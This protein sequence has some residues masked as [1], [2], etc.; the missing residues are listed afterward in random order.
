MGMEKRKG[1]IIVQ[2]RENKKYVQKLLTLTS[3]I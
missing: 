3:E 1:Y 2:N